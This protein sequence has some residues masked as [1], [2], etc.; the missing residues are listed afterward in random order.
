METTKSFRKSFK[1]KVVEGGAK[2]LT[3]VESLI[4]GFSPVGNPNF[5]P[6][7]Q[8]EWVKPLED[9]WTVI[10]KELEPLLKY[11]EYLPNLQDLSEEDAHLST[12]DR[13]KTYFLYA[14]GMKSE[15]NCERCPETTKL[16]ESVPGMV[17]AFFS[18]LSPG[19]HIPKHRGVYKGLIRYHLGLVVP[20]PNTLCRMTVGD[21]MINWEEGKSVVF[22]DTYPHEVWNDSDEVRVVLLMD[23]IRPFPFPLS[24]LNKLII[25]LV[26]LSP[27]VR[28]G[29]KKEKAWEKEFHETVELS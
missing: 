1:S 8:F 27:Y 23:V 25:Q 19:K 16:I 24:A 12:D 7:E 11:T 21:G 28:G 6:K 5:F 2:V 13:W 26:R 17:T 10:R 18:I 3:G 9:N 14:F 20:Q 29:I 22:D 4:A 15:R